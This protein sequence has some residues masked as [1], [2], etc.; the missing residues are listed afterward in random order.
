MS[1]ASVR[2]FRLSVVLLL[3]LV[4]SAS[5]GLSPR[6]VQAATTVITDCSAGNLATIKTA[7]EGPN[8]VKFNCGTVVLDVGSEVLITSSKT[9]DGGGTT[10]LSGGDA[11]RVL[12]VEG[13][14]DGVTVTLRNLTITNGLA[15]GSS[16]DNRGGAVYADGSAGARVTLN[17]LNSFLS[18][19]TAISGGAVF[20]DGEG[21]EATLVITDSE[22]SDNVTSASGEF[23]GALFASGRNSGSVAVELTR[24]LLNR[25]SGAWGGAISLDS[26]DGGSSRLTTFDTTFDHN[27]ARAGFGGAVLSLSN[28]G[29][30]AYF[31]V[32]G[33]VFS[34]NSGAN[35]G[36]VFASASAPSVF[37]FG[38]V[39]TTFSSNTGANAGTAGSFVTVSGTGTVD[40]VHSSLINNHSSL[41]GG[42]AA[43]ITSGVSVSMTGAL[44]A[45]NDINCTGGAPTSLGSNVADEASCN[46]TDPTDQIV[47]DAGL[48][49]LADNGGLTQTH[50]LLPG[51][52]AIDAAACFAAADQRGVKRPQDGNGDGTKQCDAGAFERIGTRL[53]DTSLRPFPTVNAVR[54]GDPVYVYFTFD[55]SGRSDILLAAQSVE[56]KCGTGQTVGSSQTAA[57]A[58]QYQPN[59]DRYLFVW[60]TDRQWVGSCRQLVLTLAGDEL[61]LNV[62]FV[63]RR[64]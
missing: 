49:P 39:N 19:N 12:H 5:A 36:A 50:A 46:L 2:P 60:Y 34:N 47:A 63:G 56:V 37:D 27:V 26:S 31:D 13:S 42:R 1:R 20:L 18:A 16:P 14:L 38:F 6:T 54:A 55:G 32:T 11:H 24:T 10:T 40:F 58:F 28:T 61:R 45:E 3:V 29:G 17:I 53:R 21:G 48:A 15:S 25:N 8:D 22:L 64:R 59:R 41:T 33:T 35:G 52:P 44:L 62:Q 23:G 30:S 7:L 51:S 43:L 4:L 9:I 57:G